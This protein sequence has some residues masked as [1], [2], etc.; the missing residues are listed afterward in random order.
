ME[1][2]RILFEERLW[3]PTWPLLLLLVFA[4][5]VSFGVALSGPTDTTS[6]IL[7]AVFPLFATTL[8]GAAFKWTYHRLVTRIGE[9]TMELSRD[10]VAPR[11]SVKAARIVEGAELKHLRKELRK[12][13]DLFNANRNPRLRGLVTMPGVKTAVYLRVD[14]PVKG[15]GEFVVATHHPEEFLAAVQGSVAGPASAPVAAEL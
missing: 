2:E 13:A 4:Y 7:V 10:R 5:V 9:R 12:G 8:V 14:P 6:W 1:D 15:T 11:E 3:F